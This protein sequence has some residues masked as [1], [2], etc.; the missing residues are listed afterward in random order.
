MSYRN[1]AR[2]KFNKWMTEFQ[3]SMNPLDKWFKMEK[4]LEAQSYFDF[5]DDVTANATGNPL[6]GDSLTPVAAST[7]SVFTTG[8]I[9]NT[10]TATVPDWRRRQTNVLQTDLHIAVPR[11]DARILGST[12]PM[13]IN[14]YEGLFKMAIA[15][16]AIETTI[17]LILDTYNERPLLGDLQ[18]A[19]AQPKEFPD[20]GEHMFV[21]TAD[22]TNRN[23]TEKTFRCPPLLASW[24]Y[25]TAE[26][27]NARKVGQAR[28]GQINTGTGVEKANKCLVIC[29]N[30]AFAHFK[31]VNAAIAG[32]RETFGKDVYLGTAQLYEF[33]EYAFLVLPDD[34]LPRQA[35]GNTGDDIAD[36]FGTA[37]TDLWF[38]P[39]SKWDES[40]PMM[41]GYQGATSTEAIAAGV[42]TTAHT[43][44][45]KLYP[46][47]VVEPNA[48]RMQLA[49]QLQVKPQVY[50]DFRY[51]MEKY[52][53]GTMPFQGV[54]LFDPLVRRI[55]VSGNNLTGTFVAP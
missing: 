45:Q 53:F 26:L 16:K 34:F 7:T 14:K 24:Y 47:I 8:R 23:T 44:I 11:Q 21:G 5:V 40:A 35:T 39:V 27:A 1:A 6:T 46:M 13:L 42:T 30:T 51:S 10:P 18:I 22:D 33:Q 25:L 31:N 4:T 37:K 12:H 15:R 49:T 28:E 55:W 29:G 50:S 43:T 19:A 41:R 3:T 48:F 2:V 52:I 54:R 32:N 17:K 38:P 20:S 36:K 9:R